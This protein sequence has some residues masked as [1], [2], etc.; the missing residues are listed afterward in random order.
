MNE[1]FLALT[2]PVAFWQALR[3]YA[4]WIVDRAAAPDGYCPRIGTQQ[5]AQAYLQVAHRKAGKARATVELSLHHWTWLA[6]GLYEAEMARAGLPEEIRPDEPTVTKA[7]PASWYLAWLL[8]DVWPVW[9]GSTSVNLTEW[10]ALA[11]SSD[12][13]QSAARRR[14]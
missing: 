14:G 2:A 10:S 12:W 13:E 1:E 4:Q 11:R 8:R 9:H 5:S 7:R 6:R 3:T